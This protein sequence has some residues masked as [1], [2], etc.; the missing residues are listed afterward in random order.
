M[1]FFAFDIFFNFILSGGRCGAPA[2][3]ET[4]NLRA[5]KILLSCL[6]TL[7]SFRVTKPVN[8]QLYIKLANINT[9][10][11]DLTKNHTYTLFDKKNQ[12]LTWRETYANVKT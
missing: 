12:I 11:T 8:L 2:E 5:E 9:F 6:Q 1:T 10:L 4:N 3:T 7:L